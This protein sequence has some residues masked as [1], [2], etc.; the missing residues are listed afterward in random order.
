MSGIDEQH[1]ICHVCGKSSYFTFRVRWNGL[2]YNI[3][4]LNERTMKKFKYS[5]P[6][7]FSRHLTPESSR[8]EFIDMIEGVKC[9]SCHNEE[10]FNAQMTKMVNL[11][12]NIFNRKGG[13]QSG[14]TYH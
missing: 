5:K 4:L 7:I 2:L 14:D 10:H 9:H 8:L 13:L 3:W 6:V 11:L 12:R 1:P